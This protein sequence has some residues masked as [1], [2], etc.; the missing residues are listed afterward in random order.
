MVESSDGSGACRLEALMG[1]VQQL[2]GGPSPMETEGAAPSQEQGANASLDLAF[3]EDP[4]EVPGVEEVYAAAL[5]D[6]SVGDFDS[7]VARA[8]NR[9][10]AA[11][12]EQAAGD[13]AGKMKALSRE[14]RNLRG[15]TQLPI[16]AASSIFV[17]HDSDRMDKVRAL[18]TG[19]EDT[20]YYGGCFFFDVYFPQDYPNVPPLMELETTGGGVARFNPNLY[21]DGKVCLSLLGTWHGGHESEKWKP[22]TSTLFQV[23]LSIQGMIFI[24]D[25]YFN[26]PAYDAMRGTSEGS[27]SSLKYNSEIW[28][29]NIRYA[30]L[31]VLRRPRP[32]FEEVITT[33]FRLLR[34]RIMQQCSQWLQQAA[35][36]DPLFQKRLRDAVLELHGELAKL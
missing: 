28:L 5:Q 25:P 18:I 24:A 11:L 17:R 14:M 27:S 36:L 19:P 2:R 34:H 6:L 35:G 4:E 29:N 33:H 16:Y 31:D 8:Y 12:A 13:T 10:F 22:G 9:H 20:P 7:T 30:M 32:G 15:R 23:L 26:E 1:T 21:A 3:P